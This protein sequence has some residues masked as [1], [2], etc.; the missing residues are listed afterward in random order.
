MIDRC[1]DCGALT[2]DEAEFM[3]FGREDCPMCEADDW[4]EALDRLNKYAE[5]NPTA[6][7]N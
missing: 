3:C 6:P 5:W 7:P 2:E 1:P 4:Q